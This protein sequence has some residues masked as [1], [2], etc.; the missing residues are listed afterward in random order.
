VGVDASGGLVHTAG[1]TSGNMHDE[2]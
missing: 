1:V 2:R